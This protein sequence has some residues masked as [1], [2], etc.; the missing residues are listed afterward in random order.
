MRQE[1]FKEVFK[2]FYY[3]YNDLDPNDK[4]NSKVKKFNNPHLNIQSNYNKSSNGNINN[5]NN[6]N[7]NN[8]NY[9]MN[10]LMNGNNSSTNITNNNPIVGDKMSKN[11]NN[12][13]TR[14]S[15]I[16]MMSASGSSNSLMK[17]YRISSSNMMSS[18]STNTNSTN[19]LNFNNMAGRRSG[20]SANLQ[21]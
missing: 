1:S 9:I 6:L 15:K 10:S 5:L 13:D 8:S 4:N 14:F 18:N 7:T 16:K 3:Y 19:S 11:M 2:D 21:Y 12:I 20:S 17:H